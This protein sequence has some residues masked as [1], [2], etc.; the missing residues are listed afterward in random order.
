LAELFGAYVV[1][2]I[3]PVQRSGQAIPEPSPVKRDTI[4]FNLDP[5]QRIGTEGDLPMIHIAGKATD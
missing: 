5:L 4:P 3:V 2:R 1:A